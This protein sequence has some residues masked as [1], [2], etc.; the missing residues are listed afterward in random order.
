VGRLAPVLVAIPFRT[1]PTRC[2]AEYLY[3]RIAT[4]ISNR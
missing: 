1:A 4:G 3:E 2:R